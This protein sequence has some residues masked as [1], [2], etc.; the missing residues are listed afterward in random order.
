MENSKTTNHFKPFALVRNILTFNYRVFSILPNPPGSLADLGR[1]YKLWY[2]WT[3]LT[4]AIQN[5][6][7]SFFLSWIFITMQ[8]SHDHLAICEIMLLN[9]SFNLIGYLHFWL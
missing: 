9:E 6:G 2:A 8:K 1:L 7:L 4:A 5:G 3:N